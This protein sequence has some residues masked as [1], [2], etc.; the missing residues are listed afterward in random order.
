MSKS[1][2]RVP[3]SIPL[4]TIRSVNVLT[5]AQKPFP[6]FEFF[7]IGTAAREFY[8]CVKVCAT[9]LS[10]YCNNSNCNALCGIQND[11]ILGQWIDA[12][13][14][15]QHRKCLD[16]AL[17]CNCS[18]CYEYRSISCLLSSCCFCYLKHATI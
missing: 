16:F 10:S 7:T 11:Y 5:E 3:T 9:I 12:L 18:G 1:C 15:S 13:L 4:G 2:C 17:A 6:G 8:F 14:L